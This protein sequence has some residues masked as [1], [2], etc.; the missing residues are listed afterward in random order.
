MERGLPTVIGSTVP[1][2]STMLRT[3]TMTSASAGTGAWIEGP[4]LALSGVASSNCA[5]ATARSCLLQCDQK[6]PMTGGTTH[7]T[8]TAARQAHAPLA[9]ALPKAEP[10]EERGAY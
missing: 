7:R 9:T 2:K 3:G 1:G 6:T 5:S 8:V 4:R 10:G